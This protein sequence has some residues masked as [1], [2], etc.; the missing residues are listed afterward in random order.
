[1]KNLIILILAFHSIM[2]LNAQ[3]DIKT[4][5][6]PDGNTIKYFNPKPIIREAGYEVGSS[7]Y[8][9]QT[10]NKYFINLSVLFLTMTQQ[11]ISG[12]LTIQLENSSNSIVLKIS[13]SNKVQMNGR[14]VTIALFEIDQ[15][16]QKLLETKQLKSVFFKM[17][18]KIYGSTIKN[19]KSLFIN[20]LSCFN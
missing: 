16:S 4:N 12:D 15:K 9:N 19:N 3:C 11:D 14:N 6:R 5:N 7:V 17:K 2:N 20:Q 1:M 8:Y 10:S 13:E 18:D